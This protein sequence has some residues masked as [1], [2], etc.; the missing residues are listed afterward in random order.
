[1]RFA[2]TAV[3]ITALCLLLS[4]SGCSLVGRKH[5][6]GGAPTKIPSG[7]NVPQPP[8]DVLAI[9]DAVPK[10]EPRGTRGNPPFYE[11]FGKRYH[12][13]TSAVGWVERG[14]ASWY[15]P[16]FHAASTSLGEP[17]D[18]YGMT[19]AHKTLPIPAYAEVTNLRNGRK[20]VVRINDRGPFVGDRIIDLSYTAAA[21]LDMLTAGTAP[22]EVRVISTSAAPGAAGAGSAQPPVMPA[23]PATPPVPAT[24]PP[25][26]QVTVVNA[27]AAQVSSVMFIQ[28]GVFADH[29]NARR[30]VETLLAAGLELASLDELSGSRTLHRVRV[31][32]FAT[33]EEF[34]QAMKRLREMGIR[35]ARLLTD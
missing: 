9:P 22:V 11:V 26:P 35:D 19:A 4:L 16:G 21:K 33:V 13:M 5:H 32:P 8:P 29:E 14:T 27:P 2:G 1:M 6:D 34:D 25:E 23:A 15:G 30:R 18:M 28:A 3:P 20:V 10:Y 31:G 7:S 12:V 17:Y 24:A